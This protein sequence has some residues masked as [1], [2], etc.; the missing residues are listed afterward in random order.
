M[1]GETVDHQDAFT[2]ETAGLPEASPPGVVRLRD[3]DVFDL[4]IHPV[5]KKIGDA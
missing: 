3:G 4:R 2:T 5:R 1:E